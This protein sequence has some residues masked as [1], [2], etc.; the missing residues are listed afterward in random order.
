MARQEL[1]AFY[2][3]LEKRTDRRAFVERQLADLGLDVGRLEATSPDT[4]AAEDLFPLSM[5]HAS[6]RLSPPE[7]AC[8]IS[9][10]RAWKRMLDLGH[11]RVLV[12]EDDVLL[13]RRLPAFV[14]A[15][16]KM[17]TDIDILRLETRLTKVRVHWKPRPAPPG[18]AFHTPFSYEHGSGAYVMSASCARKILSSARRFD[19]PM[20]D[21]LFSLKSPF[22]NETNIRAAVP[23]LALHRV[24]GSTD[25]PIPKSIAASNTSDG[26]NM[27]E[28]ARPQIKLRGLKKLRREIRRFGR[29]TVAAPSVIWTRLTSRTMVVPFAG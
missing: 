22:R 16:E 8:S 1:L 3:N 15:L 27:H 21:L 11:E 7:M 4:I 12:L 26:R 17:N 9:H 13:S 29:Q 2:I 25:S 18:F 24:F 6:E 19:R 5:E 23:A 20:D 10:F 28:A 14:S